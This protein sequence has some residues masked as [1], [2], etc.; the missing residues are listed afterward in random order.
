[1]FQRREMKAATQKVPISV[2]CRSFL[3][4]LPTPHPAIFSLTKFT[5]I[6]N[7]VQ[8]EHWCGIWRVNSSSTFE[9]LILVKPVWITDDTKQ[10]TVAGTCSAIA[11]NV[12]S[13]ILSVF[14]PLCFT[15]HI[16]LGKCL[17]LIT[18][19]VRMIEKCAKRFWDW[20]EPKAIIWFISK[21]G[22]C[23]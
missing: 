5:C 10:G 13:L 2:P 9:V 17:W 3:S 7:E 19:N 8:C 1:M 21:L 18:I 20:C 22:T 16:D 23:F 6:I 15:E 14:F 4:P 11:V 12:T